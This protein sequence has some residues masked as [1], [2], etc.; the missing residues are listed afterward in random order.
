MFTS[1]CEVD[2]TPSNSRNAAPLTNG[3][4]ERDVTPL[5]VLLIGHG[6]RDA[7]GRQALLDLAEAF[8]TL[9]RRRPVIP[10]FLE[11]TEPTIA[12]G[13]AECDR[14]GFA[15]VV[16]LPVLLFGA[17]HNKFDITNELD[18]QNQRYPHLI[19]RYGA[20]L[21]ITTHLLEQLKQSL[22]TVEQSLEPVD[23]SETVLL[24]VGR[25]SSDPEA[26]GEACKLAR[27]LWEGSG[28]RSVEVSFVGITHPRLEMGFE[29]AL[30]G[31]PRRIIVVPYF[32]FTGVL[33][34]KIQAAA[35]ARDLAHRDTEIVCLPE[36]G[37]SS[38][39]L[40]SLYL[41]EQ[42]AVK[43]EIQMNCQL[44]KFRIAA[45]RDWGDG[46]R[47][48]DSHGH[49][50]HSHHESDRNEHDRSHGHHHHGSAEDPYAKESDYHQRI[51]TIP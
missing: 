3:N 28:Y 8:A 18:F 24:F 6:S 27:M 35:A 41:R 9:D 51:W 5:P 37:I 40:Q 2:L 45:S 29:R 36:L 43:G 16:A 32:M 11:L 22:T 33:V 48:H 21:G 38:A 20:P 42:E 1:G 25:G 34:K 47:S 15:E 19:F 44:C 12:D 10:C 23:K 31:T 50:G 49:N 30:M 13:V 39:V 4:V 26:N 17:R 46:D 14:L 7:E